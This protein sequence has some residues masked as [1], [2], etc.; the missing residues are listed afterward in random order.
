[1]MVSGLDGGVRGGTLL[2][3]CL[4]TILASVLSMN[5]LEAGQVTVILKKIIFFIGKIAFV[6]LRGDGDIHY[7]WVN[8]KL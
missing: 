1:M 6:A 2:E 5:R 3:A 7:R 4:Q 8:R